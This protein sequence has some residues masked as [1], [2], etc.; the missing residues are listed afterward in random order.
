MT[1]PSVLAVGTAVTE[2]P[3]FV[4]SFRYRRDLV[5]SLETMGFDLEAGHTGSPLERQYVH[6]GARV[7]VVDMRGAIEKGLAGLRA[8]SPHV[9]ARRGGLIALLG[10]RDERHL[11]AVAEAGATHFLIS[12]FRPIELGTT[13]RCAISVAAQA[14]QSLPALTTPTIMAMCRAGSGTVRPAW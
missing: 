7:V 8:L 2:P 14:C 5:A 4:I 9:Q 10:A 1:I 11:G 6:S 3:V 12:P 13:V